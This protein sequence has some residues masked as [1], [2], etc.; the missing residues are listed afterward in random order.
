MFTTTTAALAAD[1][2][3]LERGAGKR[4]QFWRRTTEAGD[5]SGV[6]HDAVSGRTFV[7]NG[8]GRDEAVMVACATV[9]LGAVAAS[10]LPQNVKD[11]Q[12][13]IILDA[14]ADY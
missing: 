1:G 5:D 12:S 7:V 6:V 10:G 11:E 4:I 14:L 8:D 9:G 13:Q 2:Y 3:A